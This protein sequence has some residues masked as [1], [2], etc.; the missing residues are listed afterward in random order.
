MTSHTY[1]VC[2]W[3]CFLLAAG[4]VLLGAWCKYVEVRQDGRHDS[5]RDWCRRAWESVSSSPW[6]MMPERVIGWFISEG[7][8]ISVRLSELPRS[9]DYYGVVAAY[10]IATPVV[11]GL[12]FRGWVRWS[13]IL[14]SVFVLGMLLVLV[15]L[16]AVKPLKRWFFPFLSKMLGT[17]IVGLL[18]SFMALAFAILIGAFRLNIWLAA[19]IMLLMLPLTAL[20]MFVCIGV[21]GVFGQ[22]L[23]KGEYRGLGSYLTMA[24]ALTASLALT[25]FAMLLGHVID[26]CG[27]VP[28][29]YQVLASNVVCDGLTMLVT[30]RI[31]NLAV[32]RPGILRLPLAVWLDL[33]I[34][35]VLAYA[36]LYLGLVHT[37]KALSFSQVS[38]VMVGLSPDGQRF[39]FGCYFWTMH[40]TFI[41]TLLYL[42]GVLLCWKMKV[43]LLIVRGPLGNAKHHSNPMALSQ[44]L[45]AVLVA[46]FLLAGQACSWGQDAAERREKANAAVIEQ[47]SVGQSLKSRASFPG[48]VIRH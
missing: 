4:F 43:I 5:T 27:W 48:S 17:C 32:S 35:A 29:T 16:L 21:C 47:I 40:T 1:W 38:R 19:P 9:G 14:P 25:M 3:M 26:P 20:G 44:A 23:I 8:S 33:V 11:A 34:A 13:C 45:C 12:F 10:V 42:N 18:F 39:E 46:A 24:H 2:K 15:A 30:F 6:L 41:P 28:Q 37:S 36:S 31:L 22:K 7:E